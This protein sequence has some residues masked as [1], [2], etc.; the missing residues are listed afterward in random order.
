MKKI[1][2]EKMNTLIKNYS[3]LCLIVTV[4]VFIVYARL[5]K[6]INTNKERHFCPAEISGIK[7]NTSRTL[8]TDWLNNAAVGYKP[9][10]TSGSSNI[11]VGHQIHSEIKK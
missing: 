5:H 2:S 7:N 9:E 1:P 10:I 8:P 6:V 4:V 3:V 11:G